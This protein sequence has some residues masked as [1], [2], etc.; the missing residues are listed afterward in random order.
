MSQTESLDLDALWALRQHV[1]ESGR[2]LTIELDDRGLIRDANMAFRS[3]FAGFD[4]VSGES[5]WRFLRID[6][7]ARDLL[8]NLPPRTPVA[9]MLRET[10][11]GEAYCFHAYRIAGGTLLI[12]E[13][14]SGV[15]NEIVERMGHLAI[16]MSRL[17]RDLHKANHALAQANGLNEKLARSDSLTGL[18]NRRYFME[19]L[20]TEVRHVRSRRRKLALLMID[21]DHF[22]RVNDQF[23]H[24]GGDAVLV[25]VADL[26]RSQVRAA[27]L[28]ARLGGE[29]LVAY[30]LET[31]LSAACEVAE[32][33]RLG[34]AEL[35]PIAPDYR[36]TAS[37]GVAELR[38]EDD[39][40][41]LLKRADDLLYQA[42]T[43]GRD[44]V[45]AASPER[46]PARAELATQ[47]LSGNH[48]RDPYGRV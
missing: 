41:S 18:A 33:I 46:A 12:G 9:L 38:D 2:L 43:G 44:R 48:R 13:I 29:E 26:L 39:P 8:A 24:A 30:L 37:I 3:R 32:R 6:E 10:E 27:D 17:V 7:E 42:K 25:A 36:V 14:A 20:D 34:I 28:P 47:R 22:K 31:G 16:Q 5:P 21:L 15:E 23:G 40:E 35:R 11:D 4:R 19:R 1:M 45:V